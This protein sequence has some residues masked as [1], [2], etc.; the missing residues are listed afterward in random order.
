MLRQLLRA[1]C[2]V[3]LLLVAGHWAGTA[4]ATWPQ[5]GPITVIVPFSLGSPSDRATRVLAQHLQ[6]RLKQTVTVRN[7]PGGGGKFAFSALAAAKPDGY[8]VGL[9]NAPRY[10][11]FLLL[12]GTQYSFESFTELACLS[13][14]PSVILVRNDSPFKSLHDVVAYASAN[15]GVLHYATA[16]VGTE[17]HIAAYKFATALD[18]KMVHNSY[19]SSTEAREA[20]L[21]GKAPLLFSNASESQRV[22]R[23]ETLRCLGQFADDRSPML[24]QIPTALELG[25]EVVM[26][27]VRGIVMPVGGLAEIEDAWVAILASVAADPEFQVQ[28]QDIGSVVNYLGPQGFCARLVLAKAEFEQACSS[29]P[30]K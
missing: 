24:P 25:F 29:F 3:L 8:T 10:L 26:Y 5:D 23:D 27:S 7:N 15:P 1:L 12:S 19:R 11:S 30:V 18:L 6:E 16:G 28:V 14:D 20:V 4:W 13:I 2:A 17:D 22:V 21:R 9:L